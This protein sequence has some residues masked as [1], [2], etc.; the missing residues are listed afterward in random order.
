MDS[1]YSVG[2]S[3]L[4]RTRENLSRYPRGMKNLF[5]MV[6]NEV[7]DYAS[8]PRQLVGKS[9]RAS[10]YR[11]VPEVE[12]THETV[13]IIPSLINRYYILDL[14][15]GCSLIESLV[16]N[17]HE[18]YLLEWLDP[19]PQDIFATLEDHILEWMN[20]AVDKT[21]EDAHTSNIHL[22]GQCM[23]GTF[24]A[25]Y[26][27]L[28]QHKVKSLVTLTAPVDFRDDGLLSTWARESQVN[29][30]MMQ[31]QWGMIHHEFLQQSFKILKPTGVIRKWE[32]LFSNSWRDEFVQKFTY[33]EKWINDNVSFPGKTYSKYISDLYRDNMLASGTFTLSGKQ[34]DLS[35]ITCPVL[36]FTA[37]GDDIVPPPSAEML[38]EL[39]KSKNVKH[40]KL[41]GGHIGCVV[42]GKHQ[43]ILW[44]EFDEWLLDNHKGVVND[45]VTQ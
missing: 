35:N 23:G 13:L 36:C 17:G 24:S 20:W 40:V 43:K 33:M 42:S 10:L 8:T 19:R 45:F 26:T 4:S 12:A 16:E 25:I 27:A 3:I 30:D 32:T 38:V 7:N 5:S 39:V 28:F 18:V 22:F 29:M 37:N 34:V 15:P 9:G 44:S 6:T 2:K 21:L 41:G 31:Q 11:Y 14:Y 1:L